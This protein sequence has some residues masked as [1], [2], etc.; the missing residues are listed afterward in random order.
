MMQTALETYVQ[1]GCCGRQKKTTVLIKCL[2]WV[3]MGWCTT[4][5]PIVD[6]VT[7]T[8]SGGGGVCDVLALHLAVDIFAIM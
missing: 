8:W 6:V 5:R 3:S 4:T 2:W 7:F 1:W